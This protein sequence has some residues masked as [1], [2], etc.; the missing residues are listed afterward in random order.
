MNGVGGWIWR[1]F[2]TGKLLPIPSPSQLSSQR[3]APITLSFSCFH[4]LYISFL[5]W[6]VQHQKL[7]DTQIFLR[8]WLELDSFMIAST[9][10][11]DK[12]PDNF[13]SVVHF[14]N[15]KGLRHQSALLLSENII[16]SPNKHAWET[17]TPKNMEISANLGM[18]KLALKS[19]CATFTSVTPF[20]YWFLKANDRCNW[21]MQFIQNS[22]R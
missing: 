14:N 1:G 19:I 11:Q 9:G 18:R 8:H 21:K 4:K 6:E 7:S 5:C 15:S 16:A 2:L 3:S 20:F 10:S 12:M 17:G 22:I 13:N